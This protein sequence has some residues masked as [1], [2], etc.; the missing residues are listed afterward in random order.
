M[1]EI[2]KSFK[3]DWNRWSKGERIGAL[4]GMGLGLPLALAAGVSGLAL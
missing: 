4:L 1:I 2:L 3:R